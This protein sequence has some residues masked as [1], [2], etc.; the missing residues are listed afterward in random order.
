MKKAE[1]IKILDELIERSTNL[2][3]AGKAAYTS[4]MRETLSFVRNA[5]EEKS[6]SDWAERIKKIPWSSC[7]EPEYSIHSCKSVINSLNRIIL[8][9]KNEVE[10]YAVDDK[11][12]LIAYEDSQREKIPII[13]ISHSSEDKT[14]GDALEKFIVGLGV[15]NDQLIYT[16]HP[17][18][19][20]PLGEKIYEYLR[21]NI[22]KDVFV[23]FLLSDNYFDSPAC[24]NEMGAA[25][26]KRNDYTIIFT[27]SFDLNN[28]KF[29]NCA[30]DTKKMGITL[31]SDK[32]CK[33]SMIELKNKIIKIFSL[34]VE[35][36]DAIHLL[37]AFM[38]KITEVNND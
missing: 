23:I 38:E 25:W 35:E 19:K 28:K 5:L 24:L 13:F 10:L 29:Q 3:C 26:V 30:I 7:S 33:D 22:D 16:S 8:S 18:H 36:R 6:A 4:V 17:L 31:T 32:H 15:R 34:D 9:I 21:I 1:K 27:P 11:D 20:I 37:D 14:Y 2:T 12:K